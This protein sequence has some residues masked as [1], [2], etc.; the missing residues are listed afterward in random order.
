[1]ANTYL[2]KFSITACFTFFIKLKTEQL[3]PDVDTLNI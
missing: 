2:N 1:L 3:G